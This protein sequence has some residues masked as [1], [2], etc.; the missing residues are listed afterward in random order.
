MKKDSS[1]LVSSY[2]K[3]KIIIKILIASHYNV[4]LNLVLPLFSSRNQFIEIHNNTFEAQDVDCTC[5]HSVPS[6]EIQYLFGLT[7]QLIDSSVSC[8][9]RLRRLRLSQVQEVRNI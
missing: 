7:H 5:C 9:K 3:L 1:K 8:N 4:I 2:C 6:T